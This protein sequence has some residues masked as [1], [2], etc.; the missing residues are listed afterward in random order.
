[1]AQQPDWFEPLLS[2]VVTAT[3]ACL[4][5]PG[6]PSCLALLGA[7]VLQTA[8]AFL[9]MRILRGQSMR[10]YWAPLEL[11]RAYVLFFCWARAC[12]SRRVSWRGHHFELARDSAIVPA[13]PGVMD[14]V[15]SLVRA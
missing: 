14:R 6:K 12:V 15:R 8:C 5:L 1:M 2:P 7:I 9:S 3:L 13:Q 4:I 11:V 10:W